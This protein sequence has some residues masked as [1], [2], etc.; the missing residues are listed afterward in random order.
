[1][2][3]CES[4][5]KEVYQFCRIEGKVIEEERLKEMMRQALIGMKAM[6]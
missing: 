1:M 5:L 6:H 2:E 3:Y 4:S